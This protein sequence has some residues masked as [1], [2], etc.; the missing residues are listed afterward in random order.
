MAGPGRRE[1]LCDQTVFTG[2]D[3]VRVDP[4]DHT[5]LSVFFVIEPDGLDRPLNQA[6]VPVEF[7]AVITGTEDGSNIPVASYAW[8]SVNDASGNP[9]LTLTV[10]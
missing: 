3:F 7:S 10:T 2:I 8:D 6:A 9:R 4:A 5:R 1:L